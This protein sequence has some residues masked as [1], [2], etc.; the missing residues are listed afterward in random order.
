MSAGQRGGVMKK[1][2]SLITSSV[3][4]DTSKKT[5]PGKLRTASTSKL[6]DCPTTEALDESNPEQTP[7]DIFEIG[8][9]STGGDFE[10]NSNDCKIL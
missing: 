4:L 8:L 2:C 1:H 7:F 3:I 5:T 10:F 9:Q 6:P